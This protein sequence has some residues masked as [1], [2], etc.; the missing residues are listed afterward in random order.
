MELKLEAEKLIWNEREVVVV[1]LLVLNNSFEPAV[2]DRRLLVG[3]NPVPAPG[4]SVHYPV[5][6]EPVASQAESNQVLLNP[7]CFYGRQRSFDNLPVGKVTFHGYLLRS[8]TTR[9]LPQGPA[10]AENLLIA[11]N[12][13]VITIAGHP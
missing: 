5:S 11:A 10:E 9:L 13:L 2:C 8:P 7:W 12:P 6:L 3:P 4:S 1:R